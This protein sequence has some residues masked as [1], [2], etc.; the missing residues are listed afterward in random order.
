MSDANGPG[1]P[2]QIERIETEHLEGDTLVVRLSGRWRGHE[3]AYEGQELLVVEL[4]D[5]RRRFP[6]IPEQR[7]AAIARPGAWSAKFVL[8]EW[9][10]PGPGWEASLLIG[11]AVIPV[12]GSNDAIVA[13]VAERMDGDRQ[14]PATSLDGA[15]RL[16]APAAAGPLPYG[17]VDLAEDPRSGPLSKLLLRDTVAALHAELEQ[18]AAGTAQLRG[19]LADANAELEARVSTHADLETTHGEL[20][21]ELDALGELVRQDGAGRMELEA[22]AEAL[23]ERAAGFEMQ[24][25]EAQRRRDEL[26]GELVDARRRI[27]DLERDLGEATAAREQRAGESERLRAQLSESTA[28][29]ERLAAEAASLRDELATVR[30]TAEREIAAATRAQAREHGLNAEIAR[31]HAEL[32]G[33]NVARDSARSETTGLRT[34][35]DRLGTELAA[36]REQAGKQGELGEAKALLSDAKALSALL[37]ERQEAKRAE[38]A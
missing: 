17:G 25:D 32:A 12:P 29:H 5:G 37:R 14:V 9:S 10:R 4:A 23:S 27:G 30:A 2:I 34:E 22:S 33:A 6:A 8:P 21:R 19:R 38:T 31:L 16:D 35:L 3:R 11:D 36:L 20:R 26:E 24:L 7:R 15:A 28:A 18:R 1:P 13:N